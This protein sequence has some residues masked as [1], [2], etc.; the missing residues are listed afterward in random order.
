[1][2][3]RLTGPELGKIRRAVVLTYGGSGHSLEELNLALTDYIDCKNVFDYVTVNQPFDLQVASLLKRA[4]GEGWL[5]GLIGA[6]QQHQSESADLQEVLHT[7]LTT[8]SARQV[9]GLASGSPELPAETRAQLQAILPG[10]GTI[11]DLTTLQRRIRCV[12]RIDYADLNPPGFGSGFLVG[13]DLVLTNW[14][15]MSRFL[16]APPHAQIAKQLRFRFDLLKRTDAVDGKGR[17]AEAKINGGSPILR[18]SPA[19]GMELR[20]GTGEPGRDA[21]DYALVRLA[22]RVGDDPLPGGRSGEIRGHVK[23]RASM[24]LPAQ[25]TA[26]M[27]LQHPMRGELQ[28]AIGTVLGPNMTGSRIKHTAATQSGSSGSLVLDASLGPIALHN[29]TRRGGDREN[30]LFNT[31]VPLTR[32]VEDLKSLGAIGLLQE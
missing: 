27:V 10:G 18:F 25:A 1:M 22:E 3:M 20:G 7:I 8:A 28:F 24:P 14:H 26:L 16:E 2:R 23:L 11:L 12:C 15:V 9:V 17:V 13:P 21:L 6:L 5:P 4:N 19:A 32:I 30:Q 31:A 29:A